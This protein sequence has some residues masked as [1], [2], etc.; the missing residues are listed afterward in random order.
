[1]EQAE[2]YIKSLNLRKHPEGGYFREVY[3]SLEEIPAKALPARFEG[4]R[5]FSTSIYFLEF[6]KNIYITGTAGAGY[7]LLATT[8]N[9][10]PPLMTPR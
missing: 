5:S 1:M 9:E 2:F 6:S 4:A 3:R 8:K 10:T 7:G